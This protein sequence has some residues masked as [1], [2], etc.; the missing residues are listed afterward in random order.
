[1]VSSY[2][3]TSREHWTHCASHPN[4]KVLLKNVL[5]PSPLRVFPSRRPVPSSSPGRSL[6]TFPPPGPKT[7]MCAPPGG[8]FCESPLLSAAASS[9]IQ[10]D[11]LSSLRAS[12]AAF[13]CPGLGYFLLL[14]EASRVH[15]P[16]VFTSQD[17]QAHP[18]KPTFGVFLSKAARHLLVSQAPDHY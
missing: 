18:V 14:V 4:P 12:S 17:V 15:P 2:E 5:S 11:S 8:V 1:M 6:T 10:L 3:A 7:R 16:M 9:C 13:C